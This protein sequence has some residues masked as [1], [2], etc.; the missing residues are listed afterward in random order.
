[1]LKAPSRAAE[2]VG[3]FVPSV[4]LVTAVLAALAA[5][6]AMATTLYALPAT[7]GAPVVLGTAKG[8]HPSQPCWGTDGSVTVQA[9]ERGAFVRFAGAAGRRVRTVTDEVISTFVPQQCGQ[10][11]ELFYAFPQDPQYDGGFIVRDET[12]AERLRLQTDGPPE[13]S[14]QVMWSADRT[15]LLAR[16]WERGRGET[17]RI[18]DMRTRRMLRRVPAPL[19]ELGPQPLS[20]DGSHLVLTETI[21]RGTVDRL[22]S[23]DVASGK[24]RRL[25]P[26]DDE[27]FLRNASWS[28]TGD[29]IAAVASNGIDGGQIALVDAATGTLAAALTA[30]VASPPDLTWSPDGAFIALRTPTSHPDR[31]SLA[32]VRA[33]AGATPRPVLAASTR[34]IAAPAWSP[35]GKLLAAARGDRPRRFSRR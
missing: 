21:R 35:D 19:V 34:S 23:I 6:P 20:P 7:G 30:R 12:G 3:V 32:V 14:E 33:H 9:E 18:F 27:L 4:A 22:V 11:G 29:R 26:A 15:R 25:G 24:R 28:P 13:G 16:M 2:A 5:S 8:V 17:L 31:Q 1:M 10:V